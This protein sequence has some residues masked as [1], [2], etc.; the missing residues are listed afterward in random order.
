MKTK[1]EEFATALCAARTAL[2][3]NQ[4]EFG[5][6]VDA[7]PRSLSRW[8]VHGEL[9]HP[10]Q[11]T[12]MIVKLAPRLAAPLLVALANAMGVDASLDVATLAARSARSH[13]GL[14]RD[15]AR[16]ALDAALLSLA[17]DLDVSP[18]K[19]RPALG[20]FLLRLELS[21]LTAADVGV[22]LGK[23]A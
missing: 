10:A 20:K 21:G 6:L 16:S 13:S 1:R 22:V 4:A 8:E 17:E 23:K 9:P 18:R 5:A 12:H 14:Q 7:A 11:R 19:V 2:N 15:G 3:M